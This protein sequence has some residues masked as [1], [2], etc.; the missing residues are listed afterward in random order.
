MSEPTLTT[1]GAAGTIETNPLVI[2]S[3]RI[4]VFD[5]VYICTTDNM[6][7]LMDTRK[8]TKNGASHYPTPDKI[9]LANDLKS[10]YNGFKL[11]YLNII[12]TTVDGAANLAIHGMLTP[13][14]LADFYLEASTG[15]VVLRGAVCDNQGKTYDLRILPIRDATRLPRFTY[16]CVR[17]DGTEVAITGFKF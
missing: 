1:A 3:N 15:A 10:L 16:L 14:N 17:D 12:E 9:V 5:N 7:E 11:Q 6:S 8:F 2:E 4:I 13:A